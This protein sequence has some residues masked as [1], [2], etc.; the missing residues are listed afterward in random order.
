MRKIV[1][2]IFIFPAFAMSQ[3]AAN[4]KEKQDDIRN[5]SMC[6]NWSNGNTWEQMK[7]RAI[8]ENKFIFVDAY[9]TWCVP[10]KRMDREVFSDKRVCS[11][12]NKKFIPIKLQM[13]STV[14]DNEM[15][16]ARY[17]MVQYF[18]D[19]YKPEGYP[20]F[21]F[22]SP[23]GKLMQKTVGFQGVNEMAVL[24]KDA[25]TDPLA[26]Y[27]NEMNL[28]KEG[29]LD[30]TLLPGLVRMAR[31]QGVKKNITDEMAFLYKKKVLDGLPDEDAFTKDNLFFLAEFPLV[32][33][34]KDRYF[35]QFYTQGPKVDSIIDYRPGGNPDKLSKRVV[36]WVVRKEEIGDKLYRDNKPITGITPQW[37][38]IQQSIINKYGANVNAAFFP[39]EKINYYTNTGD[40]NN[41]VKC[42]NEKIKL[43]TPKVDGHDFGKQFGDAWTLNVYAWTLFEECEDKKYLKEAID[44]VEMAIQ[45]EKYETARALYLDT[46][47]NL[48]YKMGKTDKAIR[49]M[50]EVVKINGISKSIPA[51][52]EKMEKGLPTWPDNKP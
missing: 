35:N 11:I 42:I 21:L 15:I 38:V 8:E 26:K 28:Y 2:L 5:D 18:N 4:E 19:N 20:Y 27:E 22:F 52:L 9:A 47:G 34:S 16:R 50:R 10:C 43:I 23:E 29:K 12:L 37:D 1:I 31:K 40:W 14:K 6:V 32:L 44:W 51:N 45:L 17:N 33:S 25:I 39:D 3:K 36:L 48:L 46:K 24:L 41:Y 30:Y 13:D 7:A 49:L